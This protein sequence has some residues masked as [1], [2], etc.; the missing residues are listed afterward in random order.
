MTHIAVWDGHN[1][2]SRIILRNGCDIPET[3]LFSI[4]TAHKKTHRNIFLEFEDGLYYP[5]NDDQSTG[6]ACAM[7]AMSHRRHNDEDGWIQEAHAM[8]AATLDHMIESS[9][10]SDDERY[11]YNDN[12]DEL[13]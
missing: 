11:V 8:E 4:C 5:L 12:D 3:T 13:I 10:E 9:S 6:M 2:K 7:V 1:V